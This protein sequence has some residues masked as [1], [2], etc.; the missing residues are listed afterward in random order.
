MTGAKAIPVIGM[1]DLE[2]FKVL[3]AWFYLLDL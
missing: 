2:R 1:I 3:G